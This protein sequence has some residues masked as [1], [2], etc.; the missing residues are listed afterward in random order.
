[1]LFGF[2][3]CTHALCSVSVFD[4]IVRSLLCSSGRPMEGICDQS[5]TPISLPVL[6]YPASCVKSLQCKGRVSEEVDA[7]PIPGAI[8]RCNRRNGGLSR[9]GSEEGNS[10]GER[11]GEVDAAQLPIPIDV[12]EW[13][14]TVGR[15][16]IHPPLPIRARSSHSVLH[17]IHNEASGCARR[18]G[19][20]MSDRHR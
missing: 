9:S 10:P 16:A 8:G 13:T 20:G 3:P 15:K 18:R 17:G 14:G 7:A 2:P 6:A 12:I 11:C 1:M 19:K 4:P 5:A